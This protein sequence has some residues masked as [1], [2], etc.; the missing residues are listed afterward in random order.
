[1]A[2][3]LPLTIGGVG[4][5]GDLDLKLPVGVFDGG[6]R[7]EGVGGLRE[8]GHHSLCGQ[9]TRLEI[10]PPRQRAAHCHGGS[11][12]GVLLPGTCRWA[13]ALTLPCRLAAVQT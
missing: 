12:E 13:K 7:Q 5:E 6:Q 1:M 11:L 8:V 10:M 4:P 9:R 2:A 3:P